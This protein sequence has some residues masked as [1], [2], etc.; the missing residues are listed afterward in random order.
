MKKL[1]CGIIVV[2]LLVLI[3]LA[4]TI[5]TTYNSIINLQEDVK[6]AN[7]EVQNQMQNRALLI[8]DL[9]ATVKSYA[10][11]EEKVFE[12][13]ANARAALN[14]SFQ[15]GNLNEIS[16][17]NNELSARIVNLLS[18]AENYPQLTAGEQYTSLM[19]QLE[20]CANRIAIARTN[21]NKLVSRYNKKIRSFPNNLIASQF[22]FEIFEQYQADEQA[23]RINL[24]D[25]D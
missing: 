11:H 12:D 23:N 5:K 17:A 18:I 1:L 8:P 10:N 9:V 4:S 21:Y 22:D 25:F 16:N 2:I 7:S 13:I 15:S 24:V 6:E 20:G 3:I 14:E 19:D